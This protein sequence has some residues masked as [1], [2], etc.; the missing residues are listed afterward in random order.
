[1]ANLVAR[2]FVGQSALA[3]E[4]PTKNGAESAHEHP[5]YFEDSL[6]VLKVEQQIYKVHRYFLVRES[7]FFQ[8]MFSLPQGDS[9]TAEGVDDEHPICILDTPTAEFENLLRFLYFGMQHDYRPTIADWIATLSISTRL[10]FP[11]V[12]K[13][14][15]VELTSRLNEID[16]FDL[17]GSAIKY[18][19]QQWLKPAY[20]RIVTR[21]DPITHAEAQTI[22]FHMVIMLMRSR[23]L[24]MTESGEAGQV[25]NT[26][27]KLMDRV[28]KKE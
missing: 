17:I 21:D 11:K 18:D 15:I 1:M 13:R 19:V 16:P 5:F 12:R 2:A 27:V 24:Y 3:H 26:E 20:T 7:E 14:T 6:V 4:A 10:I 8:T 22:P 9:A 28:S 25:I 23:E